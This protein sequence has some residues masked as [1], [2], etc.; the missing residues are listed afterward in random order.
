VST[1]L[2]LLLYGLAGLLVGGAWSVHRQGAGRGV[3]ALMVLL[4]VLALAGA[5]AWT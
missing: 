3:V 4:A 5:V 2:P 1:V